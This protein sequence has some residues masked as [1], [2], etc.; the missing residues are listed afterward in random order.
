MFHTLDRWQIIRR[1]KLHSI[2]GAH[3]FV[4]R[5]TFMVF[6]TFMNPMHIFIQVSFTYLQGCQTFIL[7][8]VHLTL[9]SF[10]KLVIHNPFYGV[11]FRIIGCA[12]PI[13]FEIYSIRWVM[14]HQ[15]FKLQS[16]CTPN[17]ECSLAP[18]DYLPLLTSVCSQHVRAGTEAAF[19]D[20]RLLTFLPLCMNME[21]NYFHKK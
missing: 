12:P 3:R 18:L 15:F 9:Y 21:L 19:K 13:N 2:L 20:P 8:G 1:A 10:K 6:T 5:I 14:Y 17:I 16:N 7:L 11:K 4:T